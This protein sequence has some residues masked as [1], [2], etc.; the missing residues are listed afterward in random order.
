[1]RQANFRQGYFNKGVILAMAEDPSLPRLS[2][3]DL[4]H[5]AASLGVSAGASEK[6][7]QRMLGHKDA[8]VTLNIYAD[9]LRTTSI[10]SRTRSMLLATATGAPY[11][12]KTCSAVDPEQKKNSVEFTKFRVNSTEFDCGA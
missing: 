9:L 11:V 7:I 4:R 8:S 12:L 2:P 1:M 10:A 6:V 5:T 3:R